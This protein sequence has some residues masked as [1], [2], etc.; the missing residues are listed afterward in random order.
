LERLNVLINNAA[1]STGPSNTMCYGY[2][3]TFYF[4]GNVTTYFCAD[5]NYGTFKYYNNAGLYTSLGFLP[6]TV[7]HWSPGI[8]AVLL[9]IN[10]YRGSNTC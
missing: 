6:G 5:N 7:E 1:T 2:T 4:S 8:D 3:G 9:T 10:G